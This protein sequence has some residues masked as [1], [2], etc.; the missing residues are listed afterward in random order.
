MSS[1]DPDDDL[2]PDP[3]GVIVPAVRSRELIDML[4]KIKAEGMRLDQYV[5]MHLQDYSRSEIQR[6]IEAGGILVNGKATKASYKVRKNDHLRVG[7]PEPAHD[8]PVPEDIPLDILYQDEF[9]AVINKPA[10]MVVHPAKGNWSGTLVNALQFHFRDH[11]SRENG[12]FRA[13]I[14]H[15]LDKDTSGVILIAKDDATHRAC[16]NQFET[17]KVFKEYVALAAGELDRDTDYI[18]A[19]IKHHPHDREKMTVTQDATDP[20]AKD[21]LSYYEVLERFRGYTLVR[22]QPRTGRTHQIR[23]H[24]ASVGCPVLAD[25]LYGGRDRFTLADLVPDLPRDLDEVLI[26]RQALH[27][28]RLRF[29]HP[30]TGDWIEVEA[31]LAPDV[32]RALEALRAHRPRRG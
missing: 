27:A 8:L 19:R 16:S 14:V 29:R 7:M 26:G 22:V 23:V 9:L 3:E 10:D 28:F 12:G 21:A 17:R 13:G 2:L 25:K 32:R 15:R 30:Q 18:E 6:S 11:L 5:H 24:L 1:A 31:P 4:V 20:D